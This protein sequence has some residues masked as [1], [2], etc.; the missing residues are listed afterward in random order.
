MRRTERVKTL[1]PLLETI[2]IPLAALILRQT[3]FQERIFY[4][5]RRII[6]GTTDERSK[7][8]QGAEKSI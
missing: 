7:Q 4:P 1:E 5:L 3:I 6:R 2:D 8:L